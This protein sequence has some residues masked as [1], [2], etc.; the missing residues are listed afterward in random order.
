MKHVHQATFL[1]TFLLIVAAAGRA[2]EVMPGASPT[3]RGK[4]LATVYI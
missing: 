2:Q 4:D 1:V 3:A